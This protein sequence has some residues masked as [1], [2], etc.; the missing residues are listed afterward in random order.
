MAGEIG[1]MAID[2]VIEGIAL[3][4][5]AMKLACAI[6]VLILLIAYYGMRPGDPTL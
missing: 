4:P 6:T 3:L 5:A 1:A 2:G